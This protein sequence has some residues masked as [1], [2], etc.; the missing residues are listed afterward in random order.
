MP[1]LS[2]L[3]SNVALA[4]LLAA[5]AWFFKRWRRNDAIARTVWVLA[6][7]KLLTPPL[8][9]IPVHE[10]PHSTACALG[11]CSCGPH[12]PGTLI[13]LGS[14]LWIL[15]ALWLAGAVA[16]AFM[17]WRRWIRFRRLAA[18]AVAAPPQWQ[19][20]ATR[21]SAELRLLRR[22]EILAVPGRLPP[23]VV[24]GWRRPRV[25]LP[26]ELIGSLSGSQRKVL[27]L[28]E[29]THLRRLDH[30]VRMLELAAS[31]VYWWLPI[32]G[33][34]GR[35]LRDCEESCCDAAVLARYPQSRR[36]YARL[37][38][39][40]V[41]FAAPYPRQ[42]VP[43]ATAMSAAVDLERRLRTI[44]DGAGETRRFR[45]TGALAVGLACAIVPCS[46]QIEFGG[47][48]APAATSIE[49]KSATR[50]GIPPSV[51]HKSEIPKFG[52]SA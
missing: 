42:S 26:Q 17:A 10:L 18:H 5:V 41:D 20:Q 52:C 15:P 4:L 6:L 44:L 19:A 48:A 25:L 16:T 34:I 35:Q 9:S 28:H 3:I 1:W 38:L 32:V 46:L 50:A 39:D 40:V 45:L 49:R 21:L 2:C 29:L 33:S 8:A 11:L 51:D 47:R 12:P 7:V 43:Q 31:I 14:L 13:S 23:L 37:L 27:L 24:A 30:L 36:Q 22:P